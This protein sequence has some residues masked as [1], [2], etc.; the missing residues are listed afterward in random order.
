[1]E[2]HLKARQIVRERLE[3][4]ERMRRDAQMKRVETVY[5]LND[6]AESWLDTDEKINER[7]RG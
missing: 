1:M 7:V 4:S 5:K 2:N 3:R 6:V